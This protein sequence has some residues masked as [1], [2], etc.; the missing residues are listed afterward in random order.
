MHDKPKNRL[1]RLLEAACGISLVLCGLCL[2]AAC[3]GIY[4]RG[5]T[6]FSRQAVAEAFSA[7]AP[8]VRLCLGLTVLSCIYRIAV[9]CEKARTAHPGSAREQLARVRGSI[10]TEHG[11]PATLER[12]ARLTRRSRLLRLARG[13]ICGAAAIVFGLY[14]LDG[15]HFSGEDINGSMIRAMAW[16]LPCLAAALVAGLGTGRALERCAREQLTLLRELPRVSGA[17]KRASTTA[18]P[19][20]LRLVLLALGAGLAI[21]GAAT[22]GIA[23][24][25]AKAI[26]ICTECIGLG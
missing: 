24:V 13:V 18:A 8:I 25:L 7:I 5:D 19:A 4:R 17:E 3:V 14:A 21:F 16:F 6:P 9:P 26:N 12:L 2:M 23:D 1:Q 20:V 11:D 15:R 10:S 22:G